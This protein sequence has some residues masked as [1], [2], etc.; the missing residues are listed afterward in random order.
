M[1]PEELR[2]R[3]RATT[4]GF[5]CT[6]FPYSFLDKCAEEQGDKWA[7]INRP[8]NASASY[9]V[10]KFLEIP[11]SGMLMVADPTGVEAFL[12]DAGFTDRAN[13]VAITLG[14]IDETLSYLFDPANKDE[15]ERI[16]SEGHKL[17]ATRHSIGARKTEYANHLQSLFQTATAQRS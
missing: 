16:R 17:V 12:D 1:S 4:F 13:Y 8:V 5:S 11:G 3:M 14:T 10:A 15:L 2:L 9:L 6:Y 7:E